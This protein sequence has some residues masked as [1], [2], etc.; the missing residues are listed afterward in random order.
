MAE[1]SLASQRLAVVT[2]R[3]RPELVAL[4]PALNILDKNQRPEVFPCIIVGE[5]QAVA[6]DADCVVADE[7]FLTI[8]VWTEED[9]L[10]ACKNIV[11]EMRRAFRN[12]EGLQD[13]FEISFTFEDAIFL[14]DPDGLHSHG[15]V[16]VRA[17]TEDTV[18]I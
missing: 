5:A 15:V 1:A 8:H 4:V 11:G 9:G 17:L 3:G 10:V 7:V 12:V 2:M 6:D 18:G 16:S 13:G 14:R